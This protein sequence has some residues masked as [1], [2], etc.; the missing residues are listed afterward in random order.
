MNKARWM[1]NR[2]PSLM[3]HLLRVRGPQEADARRNRLLEVAC[4]RRVWDMIADENFRTLVEAY[5]A[6]ADDLIDERAL[7]AAR[8]RSILFPDFG[9]NFRGINFGPDSAL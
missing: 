5:E 3:L 4:W 1:T 7:A 2:S 9:I 6:F 8:R